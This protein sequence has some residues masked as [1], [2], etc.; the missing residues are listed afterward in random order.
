MRVAR[1][2][3]AGSGMSRE[4]G[5][6]TTADAY[7]YGMVDGDIIVLRLDE[8][9]RLSRMWHASYQAR[10]WGEFRAL[11]DDCSKADLQQVCELGGAG[12]EEDD[13][14]PPDDE[15]WGSIQENIK[16]WGDTGGWPAWPA[17]LMLDDLLKEVAARVGH[18]TTS[19]FSGDSYAIERPE[20]AELQAAFQDLGLPLSRNDSL[21]AEA[22]GY[23]V[24]RA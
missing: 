19:I 13:G 4:Q 23:S 20:E 8:A 10:T 21:L 24:S 15:P 9:E 17:A 22:S 18:P 1:S 6:D 12:S 16:G 7:D 14:I 11:F 5:M 2:G 3:H